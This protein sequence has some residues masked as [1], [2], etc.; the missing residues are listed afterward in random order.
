MATATLLDGCPDPKIHRYKEKSA[1][2]GLGPECR[3]CIV[4]QPENMELDRRL[5]RSFGFRLLF[6]MC[7]LPLGCVK[8]LPAIRLCRCHRDCLW[9]VDGWPLLG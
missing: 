4:D 1:Y 6:H 8:R 2:I 3:L 7:S 9:A 5:P